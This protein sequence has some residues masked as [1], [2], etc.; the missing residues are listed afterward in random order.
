MSLFPFLSLVHTFISWHPVWRA[1][2]VVCLGFPFSIYL[3][4]FLAF[5]LGLHGSMS[6]AGLVGPALLQEIPLIPGFCLKNEDGPIFLFFLQSLWCATYCILRECWVLEDMQWVSHHKDETIMRMTWHLLVS[7]FPYNKW[8]V[9]LRLTY[10]CVL[11]CMTSKFQAY[12]NLRD[13]QYNKQHLSS[14]VNK[15]FQRFISW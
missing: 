10:E 15:G 3:S 4:V 11:A 1:T 6:L 5:P 12:L 9:E 13:F 7:I 14:T 8:K 2:L